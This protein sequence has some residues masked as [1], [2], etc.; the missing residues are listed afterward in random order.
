M[1]FRN[2]TVSAFMDALA[3]GEPT[4]GGGTA[5][6][7]AGAMGVSLL[8]MVAGLPRTKTNADEEKA[9]LAAARDALAPIGAKLLD[10]ADADAASF[11]QVMAAYKLPKASDE[12]KQ[13]RKAAIQK[14]FEAAT[15]VPV[16]TL[17]AAA[18]ALDQALAVARFGNPSAASDVGVGLALLEAAAA[19]AAAN[20]QIN[21]ESLTDEAFVVRAKA[22]LA[23]GQSRVAEGARAA[24]AALTA[25]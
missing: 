21:L 14:G 16:E 9:A 2:Q 7:M 4:P 13:A 1:S 5:S 25:G 10:F 22:Q 6:A 20:V 23:D 12:E 18:E 15:S 24:R 19:G 17:L 8:V 3:S 11:D